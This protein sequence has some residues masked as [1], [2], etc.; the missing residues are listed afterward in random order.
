MTESFAQLR[1]QYLARQRLALEELSL[2]DLGALAQWLETYHRLESAHLLSTWPNLPQAVMHPVLTAHLD[3]PPDLPVPDHLAHL[4]RPKPNEHWEQ[5]PCHPASCAARRQAMRPHLKTGARCLLLGDDDLLSL[6]L[7]DLCLDLDLTVLDIDGR[8]LEFLS[9]QGFGGQLIQQDLRQRHPPGR[10]DVVVTDPPWAHQG[11]QTFLNAALSCLAPGGLFF[12][13]T[14]PVMLENRTLFEA[15]LSQLQLMQTWPNLNRYDYPATMLDDVL[16]QL[17]RY[18]L[19]PEPAGRIFGSP[20]LWADFFLY[21]DSDR[22]Q[23]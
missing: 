6:W 21:R 2:A 4:S 16:F 14:Q 18:D 1:L 22:W 12:L 17:A 9:A 13:S 23:K 10:Y 11:M 20:W 5:L 7:Q 19:D 15:R 3:F 8:L